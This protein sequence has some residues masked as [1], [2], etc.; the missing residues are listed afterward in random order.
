MVVAA[1]NL[2]PDRRPSGA[3]P[4]SV[5]RAS[6]LRF[7]TPRQHSYLS[8]DRIVPT[9]TA[10]KDDKLGTTSTATTK[11][12]ST[13]DKTEPTESTSKLLIFSWTYWFILTAAIGAFTYYFFRRA[14]KVKQLSIKP[15]TLMDGRFGFTPSDVEEILTSIGPKG[16]GIY[17]E[18]NRVDFIVFPY[19]LRE[20]LRN[21][22][23]PTSQQSDTVREVLV[24]VYM[25]GD[26]LENVCVAVLLKLYPKVIGWVA[27]VG[28][29]ANVVKYTGFYL[30]LLS[31][32]YEGYVWVQDVYFRNTRPKTD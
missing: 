17:K 14:A 11:T 28:C 27:W 21:T 25:A 9:M 3:V 26:V 19:V 10:I 24:N 12:P 31:I 30:A 18:I 22:L 16:R 1:T 5:W 15:V 2:R 7:H 4:A 8:I 29:A 6:A 13:D 32:L 20:Y 23:P